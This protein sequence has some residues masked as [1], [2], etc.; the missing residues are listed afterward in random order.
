MKSYQDIVKDYRKRQ[1]DT[2]V[3]VLSTGLTYVDELA[4]DTG[5]L[6][7]T[8]LMN[9]LTSSV[10]SALPFAVIMASEGSKVLLGRKPTATGVKDGAYRMLK[11]GVAMGIGTAVTAGAGFWAAIPATMGVR[12]LF[13]RYRVKALTGFRVQSRIDR[14]RELSASLRDEPDA[15][16]AASVL[17]AAA[18]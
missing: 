5:L 6:E 4:V 15:Q 16:D 18:E 8:G 14:L 3:D 13:D 7:E 11:T 10:C 12:A 9:E 17:P 2:V 1:R